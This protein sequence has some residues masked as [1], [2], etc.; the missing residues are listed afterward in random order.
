MDVSHDLYLV[1]KAEP[2][3]LHSSPSDPLE[4]YFLFARVCN[5]LQNLTSTGPPFVCSYSWAV[6]NKFLCLRVVCSCGLKS[7]DKCSMSKL[8]LEQEDL[9][10]S[11]MYLYIQPTC[12]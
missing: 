9:I 2:R 1:Y 6:Q 5:K 3:Q 10:S 7:P 11:K 4:I 8:S 12:A